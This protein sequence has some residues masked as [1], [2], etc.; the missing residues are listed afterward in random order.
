MNNRPFAYRL[1]EGRQSR[2][3]AC[4]SK[5][6]SE[7]CHFLLHVPVICWEGFLFLSV[8]SWNVRDREPSWKLSEVKIEN[9]FR[10]YQPQHGK[11]LDVG[12]APQ[13]TCDHSKTKPAVTLLLQR[14]STVAAA[15]PYNT[16]LEDGLYFLAISCDEHDVDI[17]LA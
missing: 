15:H 14:S 16:I 9:T 3:T 5:L 13:P 2:C 10:E 8:S 6:R 4:T 12:I 7:T 17:M 11:T 1:E